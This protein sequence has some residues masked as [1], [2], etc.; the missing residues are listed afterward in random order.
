MVLAQANTLENSVL[1]RSV[2]RDLASIVGS[3]VE[4][5]YGN[6]GTLV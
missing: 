1:A 6:Y 5:G 3:Q 4:Q 2:A